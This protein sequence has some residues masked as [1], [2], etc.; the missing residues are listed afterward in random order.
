MP[1]ARRCNANGTPRAAWQAAGRDHPWPAGPAARWR[2]PWRPLPAP[3]RCLGRFRLA[4]PVGPAES[5]QR[6]RRCRAAN[7]GVRQHRCGRACG[8][9][10]AVVSVDDA[11]EIA[12]R[13]VGGGEPGAGGEQTAAKS[14][15]CH[16]SSSLLATA[17]VLH[18]EG[19]NRK[20]TIRTLTG[21]GVPERGVGWH[22]S[23]PGA[24]REGADGLRWRE[25]PARSG[26]PPRQ[27]FRV[28]LR[29]APVGERPVAV[30]AC[31]TPD[32]GV[33][34]CLRLDRWSGAVAVW[35]ISRSRD[36]GVV[37]GP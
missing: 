1:A 17:W 2:S 13:R 26:P 19:V 6:R 15:P 34:T 29:A 24:C 33:P 23:G 36:L 21:A 14:R 28:T 37:L 16:C 25:S 10:V 31:A 11:G 9:V 20:R 35:P 22:Q 5:G 18:P 8:G 12:Y 27:A 7:A 32:A 4:G 3:C 30:C